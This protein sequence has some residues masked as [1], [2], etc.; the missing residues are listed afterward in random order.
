MPHYTFRFLSDEA[1]PVTLTLANDAAAVAEA[2]RA[3]GDLLFDA[4]TE[5]RT[6]TTRVEVRK[7]DGALL[8]ELTPHGSE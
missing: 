4:A 1:E 2:H 5:H 6:L 7:E 3:L 8:A